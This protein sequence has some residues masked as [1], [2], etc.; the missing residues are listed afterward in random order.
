M[1]S[2]KKIKKSNTE[3]STKNISGMKYSKTYISLY[4]L[5][6]NKYDNVKLII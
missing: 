5:F 4:K 1:Y 6:R 3:I 2:T